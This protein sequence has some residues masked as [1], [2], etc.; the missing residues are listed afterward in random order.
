MALADIAA[1]SGSNELKTHLKFHLI[2]LQLTLPCYSL[3][4]SLSLS[5]FSRWSW[6]SRYQNVSILDFIGTEDD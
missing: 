6:V 2:L 4:L 5:P 1:M 3:S